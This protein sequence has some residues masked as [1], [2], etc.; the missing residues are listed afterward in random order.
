[1]KAPL[2]WPIALGEPPKLESIGHGLHGIETREERFLLESWTIHLYGYEADLVLDGHRL[3]IKPGCVGIVAPGVLQ[4]YYFQGRA[5][6][7]YAHFTLAAS[8]REGELP[9]AVMADL[10]NDFGAMFQRFDDL[11]RIAPTLP[12]RAEAGLWDI[13]WEL[14]E[15]TVNATA[16]R[17][18]GHVAVAR[19]CSAV[20]SRLGEQLHLKDIAL[21]VG[22]SVSHL[23]RLFRTH[24][25][26]TVTEYVRRKRVERARHLLLHSGLSIKQVAHEVGLSN[27]QLF[28]KVIRRTYGVSPRALRAERPAAPDISRGRFP[29]LSNSASDVAGVDGANRHRHPD[30]A[31][32]A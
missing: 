25:D 13:L 32:V 16:G 1:M 19:A 26:E 29:V 9:I 23:N 30:R 27:L 21:S 3:S 28:N 8:A 14:A 24:F 31:E 18:K 10:G 2:S 6:H 15:R 20:E 17:E 7:L 4:E 5:A 12:R 22:V 11:R